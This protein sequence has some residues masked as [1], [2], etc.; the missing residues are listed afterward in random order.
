MF[1]SF[2][3]LLTSLSLMAMMM[4]MVMRRRIQQAALARRRIE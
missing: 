1:E 2:A 3:S 4:A